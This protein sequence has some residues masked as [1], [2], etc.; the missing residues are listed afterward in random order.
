[1]KERRRII[2]VTGG[3]LPPEKQT[4]V[5]AWVEGLGLDPVQYK[6]DFAFVHEDGAWTLHLS[7]K[8]Q[9]ETG[10]DVV[11]IAAGTVVSEPYLVPLP[12]G[13]PLPDVTEGV[14]AW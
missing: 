1:M 4:L 14:V 5:V 6:E 12:P 9:T 10:A 13:T 11:D 3:L 7:R 8:R 2:N